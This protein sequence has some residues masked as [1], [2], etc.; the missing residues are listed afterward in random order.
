MLVTGRVYLGLSVG[1]GDAIRL[2]DPDDAMQAIADHLHAQ[3]VDGCTCVLA[4]GWFLGAPEPAVIV[5]VSGISARAL[6]SFL[7]WLCVHFN[8]RCVG[9]EASKGMVL[10][11]RTDTAE[12]AHKALPPAA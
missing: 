10:H 4:R 11:S 3:D 8:Q 6:R 5:F 9:W 12:H 1:T 2:L 7:E